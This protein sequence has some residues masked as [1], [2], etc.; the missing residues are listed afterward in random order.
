MEV[1]F[2]YPYAFLLFLS[3]PI[4]LWW[5]KHNKQTLRHEIRIPSLSSLKALPRSA[6][7]MMYP[8]LKIL[9]IVSMSALIIAIARPQSS[10]TQRDVNV[11]G[12]D[13]MLV[14]DISGS[15]LAEDLKPNRLESAKQKAAEFIDGR[16]YDRI[17]LVAF[18]SGAFTLC[19]LTS[20]HAVLKGLLEGLESGIIQDGT[21]IGDGIGIAVDRLRGSQA[22]SKV[23]I[24]LTDGVNNA[25]YIDPL[26]A[27]SI[28]ATYNVRIYVIGVGTKGKAPYPANTM[29]GTSYQYVDVVIDEPLMKKI[30]EK[31]GGTYF[32]A[33]DSENLRSV[34]QEIDKM[35]KT[36]IKVA[37]LTDMRDLFHFP[38]WFALIA[39]LLEL[40]LR[41]SV[42]RVFP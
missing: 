17:G 5:E 4:M 1:L 9:R 33:V 42:F 27:A 15:M 8:L 28:A 37:Q 2:L 10:K 14:Q 11:E 31:T 6:K 12:I 40:L 36:R 18:S 41:Y 34:Y 24:L 16:P 23:I 20:D 7:V 21:A 13:I 26:M 35:E 29:F 3:I 30:A 39:L 38:L 25:G 32:R 19:P 22:V